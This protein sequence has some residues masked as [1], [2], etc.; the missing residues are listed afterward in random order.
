M[1]PGRNRAPRINRLP[2]VFQSCSYGLSFDLVA[3][4]VVTDS[5]I[6]IGKV[7]AINR[8]GQTIQLVIKCCEVI[9]DRSIKHRIGLVLARIGVIGIA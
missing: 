2:V 4:T 5:G 9:A 8:K 3:V 7:S 6:V 1:G